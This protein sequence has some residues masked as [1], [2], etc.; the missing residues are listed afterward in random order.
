MSTAL[1]FVITEVNKLLCSVTTKV[2]T[3]PSFSNRTAKTV[4][5]LCCCLN[6][7]SASYSK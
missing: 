2:S 1:R 7:N 3:V 6:G 4:A 5:A